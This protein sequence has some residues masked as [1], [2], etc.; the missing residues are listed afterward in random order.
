MSLLQLLVGG[1]VKASLSRSRLASAVVSRS[2]NRRQVAGS[3]AIQL[4]VGPQALP[5][6]SRLLATPILRV[7]QYGAGGLEVLVLGNVAS[8]DSDL[9]FV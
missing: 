9:K 3:G 2:S 6:V 5:E 7:S 8:R 4:K 1:I